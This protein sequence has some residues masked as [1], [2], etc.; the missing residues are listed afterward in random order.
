M[1][2]IV[3]VFLFLFSSILMMGRAYAVNAGA[4]ANASCNYERVLEGMIS[5]A[6][7]LGPLNA[8][9]LPATIN[10]RPT[11]KQL[12]EF[13]AMAKKIMR[14]RDLNF[15]E[16]EG[17]KEINFS[18]VDAFDDHFRD[19]ILLAN[20]L[21]REDKVTLAQYLDL[22]KIMG[23]FSGYYEIKNRLVHSAQ[24]DSILNYLHAL[25]SRMESTQWKLASNSLPKPIPFNERKKLR[26]FLERVELDQA[27]LHSN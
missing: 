15:T 12:P 3:S 9:N 11:A 14:K 6:S 22:Q 26:I 13:S 4:P 10:F 1:R 2:T 24:N 18:S 7:D 23:Q 19:T 27:D 16:I 5:D 21:L 8:R 17:L 25:S 20:R